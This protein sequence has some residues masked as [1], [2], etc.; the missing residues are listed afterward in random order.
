MKSKKIYIISIEGAGTSALAV[1]YKN[2]G[3][4]VSGSDNGDHFYGDILK[5][6]NIEVFDSYDIENI[7]K[8][9]YLAIYST[10]V[11][12]DNPELVELT[13]QGVPT[14]SYPE[15]LAELFNQKMGIAVC[16]THGKTTTTAILATVFKELGLKPSALV[17]SKVKDW[18][19]NSLA[20]TGDYFIIEADEY[21]NKLKN[22]NPWAVI[23]TSVDY[24]HP[25]FYKTFDDYKQAF[26]DFVK[27]IP[28]HGFLIY[29]NDDNNVVEIAK[30]ASCQK[31]SYGF[32]EDSMCKIENFE[33]QINNFQINNSVGQSFEVFYK[34]DLLGKFKIAL[35]GKHNVLNATAV[36]ALG[37]KLNLNSL[38]IADALKT[39]Q[40]TVRRFEYIGESQGAI[41][42]DDYAHHPQEIITT[43]KTARNIFPQKNIITIFHPH[44]FT[45]TEALLTEFSQSF[46]NV[47]EVIVLD[48]YGSARE[49]SGNVSSR[50][51]VRLINRHDPQKA[52]Y[53]PTI[54]E[55]IEILKNKIGANDLIISMGAGD[56][57]RV[58]HGL[59]NKYTQ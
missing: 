39:F 48:I 3:Y 18:K 38:R 46:D 43:L 30:Q 51:L 23:L 12:K 16:G 21:Q 19:G 40:G 56:V 58:T 25:D 28:R 36:I 24:D 14:L 22:Y 10:C 49:T 9:I 55:A 2:L 41:L 50:D 27:K 4:E 17:G 11:S 35:P 54:E 6:N 37:H 53:V 5:R 57:W 45:R 34:E 31:I 20:G 42:I 47:N 26:I 1:I 13:R 8:D 59:K 32:T 44:S 33:F 15:A 52:R 7:P 29:C